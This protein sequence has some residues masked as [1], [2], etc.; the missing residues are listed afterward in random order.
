MSRSRQAILGIAA[1][2]VGAAFMSASGAT[3]AGPGDVNL[4]Q[5]V[6]HAIDRQAMLEQRGAHAGATND[7]YLPLGF[8]GFADA[9]L[10]PSRPD[11]ARARQLAGW[12][13]GDPMRRAVMYTCNTGPCIP[14]AQIV[15]ANLAQ[16]G[17]DVEIQSFPRAVQFTKA[18]T[19]GE[20]FDLTLEGWHMDYYDP[21]GF[22]FLLDGGTIRPAANTNFSYY[23]DADYRRRLFEANALSG[24]ARI[25]ALGALDVHA[26]STAAPLATF[27]TDYNREF[28]SARIGCHAYH[29][30]TGTMSLAALCL[31]SGTDRTFR[32]QLDTDIDYVDPALAY[33]VISWQIEHATC[34]RLLN[35]PDEGGPLQPEIALG[36][37]TVSSDGLTYTFT[38][39]DG[40]RFSRPQVYR[41]RLPTSSTRWSGS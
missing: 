34:A 16:I 8:P 33:Y 21:Y 28:F 32:W 5:A 10:Y 27:A 41:S 25:D 31:R 17:I 7:Q 38:L 12:Q 29:G 6:N 4:K 20:P 24:Q 35:Y 3:A 23:D 36:F 40:F 11:V 2:C 37:P 30:P 13:P 18:A 26:A 14:T 15:Q 39:R 9:A 19:R 22:L 1:A